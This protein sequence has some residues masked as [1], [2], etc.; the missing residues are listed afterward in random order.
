MRGGM[1]RRRIEPIVRQVVKNYIQ[2]TSLK[3]NQ[4]SL[5]VLLDYESPTPALVWEKIRSISSKHKITLC[6]SERWIDVPEGLM[7]DHVIQLKE[8]NRDDIKEDMLG[9]D[10]LLF[11][12]ANYS[13]LSKL[14]LTIDDDLSLWIAIQMQLDGKDIIIISDQLE[15]K[16]IRHLSAP[17]TVVKRIQT[18]SRQIQ[19]D[20]VSV[21]SLNKIEQWLETSSRIQVNKPP[22][23]LARHIQEIANEGEKE[24]T[25]PEQSLITPMGRDR[26]KELGVTINKMSKEKGGRP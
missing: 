20:G 11:P 15:H 3:K 14:A 16:G 7:V 6:L 18:Y 1:M 21:V 23:I 26:A 2:S 9:T 17:A 5:F 13:L 22:L 24:L 19:A 8:A 10:I 12:T 25:V 4:K